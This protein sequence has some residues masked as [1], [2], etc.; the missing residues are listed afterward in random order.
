MDIAENTRISVLNRNYTARGGK[1]T[2]LQV[3]TCAEN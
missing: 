1:S 2:K 3:V